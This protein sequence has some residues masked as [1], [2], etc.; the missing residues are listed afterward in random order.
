MKVRL[1]SMDIVNEYTRRFIRTVETCEETYFNE[2]VKHELLYLAV[3]PFL[4]ILIILFLEENLHVKLTMKLT[5][6]RKPRSNKTNG[7]IDKESQS[8]FEESRTN[9]NSE[10]L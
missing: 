3:P 5:G 1:L 9:A 10:Y 4:W 6:L 7:S 8:I 2:N